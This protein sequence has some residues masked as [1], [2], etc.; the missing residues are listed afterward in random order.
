VVSAGAHRVSAAEPFR[1]EPAPLAALAQA[2]PREMPGAVCRAV[3]VDLPRPGSW[4]EERLADALLAE[5]LAPEV[6]EGGGPVAWRG[7]ERWVRSYEPVPDSGAAALTAGDAVLLLGSPDGPLRTAAEAL[8][9]HGIRTGFIRTAEPVEPPS[10]E[11]AFQA[12]V[13][14]G[15]DAGLRAAVDEAAG[16]LGP[17]AAAVVDLELAAP[18]QPLAFL[19]RNEVEAPLLAAARQLDRLAGLLDPAG[20]GHAVARVVLLTS[21]EA[22]A[23]EPGAAV[24]AAVHRWATAFAE[25]RFA[26]GAVPW[27]A[28]AWDRQA[29]AEEEQAGA[30]FLRLLALGPV[31]GVVVSPAGP[32]AWRRRGAEAEGPG[33][34]GLH[35]RPNLRN[36]YVAPRTD[37]ERAVA[38]V[39]QRLLGLEQVG[40]HDSFFDLGGDSLMATQV[41]TRI[42]E[43]FGVQ[44]Q[45]P[46]FFE[47]PTPA[48]LAE[49]IDASRPAA[50]TEEIADLIEQVDDLS[51]EE[52]ERM[53][54]ERGVSLEDLE[55]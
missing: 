39:W 36:P 43:G 8:A 7:G 2:L 23:A 34:V 55:I 42:R 31:A 37:T 45:L 48:A 18:L 3:D 53:L 49:R 27:T 12:T 13:G 24:R 47:L 25:R 46:E 29:G 35:A 1:P 26:E 30:T 16:R 38:E 9:V 11:P 44:V 40:V 20:N 19:P 32:E 41:M 22:Q 33:E 14:W 21:L 52:V 10:A 6:D 51:P 5:L 17:F 54:A 15:D 50:R 4:Q 28:V